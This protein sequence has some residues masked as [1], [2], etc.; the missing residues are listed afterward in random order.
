MLVTCPDILFTV[1]PRDACAITDPDNMTV[2][3]TGGSYYEETVSVYGLD[4]W[5]EDLPSLHDGRKDHACTSFISTEGDRVSVTIFLLM[6]FTLLT[7]WRCT[8]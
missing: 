1:T 8:W 4:G 7:T 3:I 2:I 6:L 5:I